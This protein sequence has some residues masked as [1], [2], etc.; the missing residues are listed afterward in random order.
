LKINKYYLLHPV[1]LDFIT[2]PTLKMD[3][4][5]QI[6]FGMEDVYYEVHRPNLGIV[7]ATQE[8]FLRQVSRRQW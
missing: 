2:L 3:G 6:T 5:T 4:Q 1:D 8:E 7:A